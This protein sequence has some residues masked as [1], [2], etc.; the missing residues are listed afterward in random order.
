VSLLLTPILQKSAIWNLPQRQLSFE[1]FF[2]HLATL[3][4][5][6]IIRCKC[7]WSGLRRHRNLGQRAK[8]EEEIKSESAF[9]SVN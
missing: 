5:I 7:N 1:S 9:Q 3:L 4:H 8:V 2:C 6:G